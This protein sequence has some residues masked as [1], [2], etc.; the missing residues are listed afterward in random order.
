MNDSGASGSQ[1]LLER[2]RHANPVGSVGRALLAL[3][4]AALGVVLVWGGG[5][6]LSLGGTPWYLFSGVVMLALAILIWRRNSCACWL[7]AI[8]TVA[9][10]GWALAEVGLDCWGL[11][12]RLGTPAVFGLL[13]SLPNVRRSLDTGPAPLGQIGERWA[14]TLAP[15]LFVLSIGL[16]LGSYHRFV[17]IRPYIQALGPVNFDAHE[18]RSWGGERGD[19][20]SPANQIT[21]ANVNQLKVAWIAHVGGPNFEGA[22]LKI[23]EAVIVCSDKS[24]TSLNADTGRQNWRYEPGI[25]TSPYQVSRHCRGVAYYAGHSTDSFCDQRLL[26]PTVDDHLHEIDLNTGRPCPDFGLGGVLDLSAGIGQSRPG[27]HLTSSPP[28]IF[29]DLAITGSKV[30]DNVAEDMPSGVVR[31]FSVKTGQLVWAWDVEHSVHSAPLGPGEFYPRGGP[32]AWGVF[33][34]D[35][36]LRLVYLGVGTAHTGMWNGHK[37]P[38]K[39]RYEASMVALDANTG[40]VKWSFQAVHN[41]LWDSDIGA[42]P[43]I[44]DLDQ[45]A[46]RVAALVVPTKT[47]HVFVL[48]RAT[49]VPIVSVEERTVPTAGG[50]PGDHL[51][52]TQ[53]FPVGFPTFIPPQLH[54]TDMWGATILDQLFC[55][56]Q[57]R[58]SR[59]EGA[60]T[61]PGLEPSISF[62]DSL[63]TID[64]GGVSVDPEREVMFVNADYLPQRRQLATKTQAEK[65]IA[66]P[67][68]NSEVKRQVGADY[69]AVIHKP[70]LSFLGVPCNRPPWGIVAA[71]DLRTNRLLWQRPY[72][73]TRDIAPLS[74]PFPT[75]TFNIGGSVTT[76]SG[77]TFISASM[78]YYVRAYNTE[79]GEEL[80][81]A[82]LPTGGQT[83]PITYISAHTGRQ[84]VLIGA[85]GHA[86]IKQKPGD[87]IIAYALPQ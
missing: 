1:R 21:P 41:N 7:S 57:F 76:R 84:Y 63:S 65:Q 43:S 70:M 80:W 16:V 18:W 4:Y 55:R 46:G 11:L 51:S 39:L 9:T 3:V 44:V 26:W 24:V 50:A 33:N 5:R 31:A 27:Y 19:K 37:G 47:G 12:P 35:P 10:I 13:F 82:R 62:P 8:Y 58:E 64:W 59:Y 22:P 68:Y 36:T 32:N 20:F 15:A 49:G 28:A 2:G 72:G 14:W 42:Q 78:D 30:E 79:T 6:L 66:V 38:E 29:E 67:G 60:Y 48:D 86:D 23:G 69:V 53:P 34:V 83:N 81:R 87:Y 85:T 73:T 54:E 40:D 56:I 17:P 75:G 71:V 45:P 52:H 77:L 25:P 61:P 74:I